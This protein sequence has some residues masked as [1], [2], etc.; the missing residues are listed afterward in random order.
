MRRNNYVFLY[1]S[2]VAF[3][4]REVQVEDKTMPLIDLH[5]RTDR[6]TIT[7]GHRVIVRGRQAKELSQFMA[8]MDETPDLTVLGWLRSGEETVVMAERVTIVAPRA[9]RKAAIEAIGRADL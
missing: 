1:G 7:E 2:I 5:L 4:E 8:V 9:L 6:P 3:V